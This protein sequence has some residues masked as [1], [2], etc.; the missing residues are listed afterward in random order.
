MKRKQRIDFDPSWFDYT[1]EAVP[2]KGEKFE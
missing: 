1:S 2:D